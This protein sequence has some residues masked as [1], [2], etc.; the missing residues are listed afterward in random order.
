MWTFLIVSALL[1]AMF[2]PRFVWIIAALI[3]AVLSIL[4]LVDLAHG[5][6]GATLVLAVVFAV[7]SLWSCWVIFIGCQ[8][9]S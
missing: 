4:K 8:P 9:L 2:V 1:C 7:L 3:F 5:F 6:V